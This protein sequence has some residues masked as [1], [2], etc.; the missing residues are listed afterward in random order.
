MLF[1]I[2]LRINN[3]VSSSELFQS[4]SKNTPRP[5]NG[6]SSLEEITLS[7][8]FLISLMESSLKLLII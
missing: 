1:F 6:S 2:L 3:L 5:I 8:E 4:N 7:I